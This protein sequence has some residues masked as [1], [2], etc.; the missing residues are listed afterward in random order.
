MD[1][2]RIR[3]LLRERRE[4]TKELTSL[5]FVIRGSYFERFSTCSRPNCACHEGKRHGPRA[6]VSVVRGRSQ[7]QH[8]VPKDQVDTVREGIRQYQ[9]LLEIVDRVTAINL[10]LM[11]G[12][13]LD[14]SAP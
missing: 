12:G 6:Y 10:E 14:D 13:V 1:R 9:R 5:S 8:Y 4:L 11:R 3:S 2:A 7:K